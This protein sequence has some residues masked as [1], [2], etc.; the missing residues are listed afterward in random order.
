MAENIQA[1][2]AE[3]RLTN[4]LKR[5]F[6]N[7][8]LHYAGLAA[9]TGLALLLRLY[10]LGEWGFWIDEVL[11]V[12]RV[13]G[14]LS[15]VT[16]PSFHIIGFTMNLFGVSDWSARL[17]PALIGVISLPVIYFL[18]RRV[19][20]SGAAL[21][22][23]LFL[24]LSPW[25][26]YWSQNARFYTM[27]LFFYT[28]GAFSL[29]WWLETD[30]LRYLIAGVIF[31][32][33]AAL[34]RMN[35]AFFGPVVVVYLLAL[36]VLPFGRPN[37]LRWRNLLLLAVPAGLFALYQIAVVGFVD[38]FNEWILGRTHNPLRV[39]FSVIYDIGL[40]LFIM[41]ILGGVY[42]V[43][44]KNRAGLF[45]FLG[46]LV[47]TL[48]L[49]AMSP[50][51]QAFSRY[52]FMT[53]PA[54][55]ILAAVAA[56]EIF[57]HA[58]KPGKLLAVGVV[59]LLVAD[60]SSQNFLYFTF[61]NGNRENFKDA[62]A[63]VQERMAPEDWVVTTR[64][65]IGEYYMGIQPVDSNQIDLDGIIASGRPAWFVMDNRTH[66]SDELQEWFP[67]NTRIEGV[68]DVFI[69]GRLMETRVY[70]YDG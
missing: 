33:L 28:I 42:L 39:L 63:M 12:N 8:N 27:L 17:A 34:E 56:K 64:P 6:I 41:G 60:A 23:V 61:Q 37:G 36:V 11:T 69:P 62:Y 44:K 65:E 50:F 4:L 55:A 13:L 16:R 67:A 31:V 40:P 54:F 58:Q 15:D 24:A 25:H 45:F 29:Y 53:L 2:T 20:G 30:R 22:A 26:L 1:R 68:F 49:V 38:S 59:L 3:H 35:A 18:T 9:V 57:L 14:G 32:G 43:L 70:Y 51:T 46:A 48:T 19:F 10:R 52:V 5:V 21:L 7:S 66:I 47:P